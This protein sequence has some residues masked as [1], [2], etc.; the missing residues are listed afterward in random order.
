MKHNLKIQN[1]LGKN[2]KVADALSRV[3]INMLQQYDLVT[4]RS[5]E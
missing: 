1:T 2:N 3:K 5:V 4:T